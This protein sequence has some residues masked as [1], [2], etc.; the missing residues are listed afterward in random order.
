LSG[1]DRP[2]INGQK[3]AFPT[4]PQSLNGPACNHKLLLSATRRLNTA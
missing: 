2:F 1:P 4:H 3:H